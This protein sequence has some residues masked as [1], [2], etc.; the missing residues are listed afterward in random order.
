MKR[1]RTLSIPS[2]TQ[3]TVTTTK[4]ARKAKPKTNF[5]IPR[6][7][8]KTKIGFPKQLR[9]KHRYVEILNVGSTLGALVTHNFRANGMFDPNQTGT[10]H[11][12]MYYDQMTAIYNHWTVVKSKISIQ[13]FDNTNG[14]TAY[15]ASTFGCYIEDDTTITPG[16]INAMCEQSTAVWRMTSNQG[17]PLRISKKWDAVQAFGPNPQANDDLQGTATADPTEQQHFLFFYQPI[18][19]GVST[20]FAYA[21]VTIEYDA[22]WEELRNIDSS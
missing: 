9:M 15:V 1:S 6:S 14:L 3:T 19:I 4:V 12:P 2:S 16:S 18:A 20:T 17:Q 11:Q 10:G 7:V 8:G 13:L 5:S 21:L 22:I